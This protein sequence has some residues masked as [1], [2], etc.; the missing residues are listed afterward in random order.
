MESCSEKYGFVSSIF[1][2]NKIRFILA[3]LRHITRNFLFN[4]WSCLQ[5]LSTLIFS[6]LIK[7][8]NVHNATKQSQLSSSE[9]YIA[10]C[11]YF[12][13]SSYLVIMHIG[14]NDTLEHW[15]CFF[16]SQWNDPTKHGYHNKKLL[17]ALVSD[18][19]MC[20]IMIFQIMYHLNKVLKARM[21]Y[22]S[23]FFPEI[24]F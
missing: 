13:K 16:N 17:F 4:V 1:R 9:E 12:E 8:E 19:Q 11:V 24:I 5:Y 10:F 23:F 20:N 2:R 21:N 3:S 22:K 7:I 6:P 15:N 18:R 14:D